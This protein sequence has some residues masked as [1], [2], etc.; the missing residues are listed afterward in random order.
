M[1]R[2]SKNDIKSKKD[3]IN[4]CLKHKKSLKYNSDNRCTVHPEKKYHIFK[5]KFNFFVE[6]I[7]TKTI[8]LNDK[9]IDY[10]FLYQCLRN[11]DKNK[12]PIMIN[13]FLSIFFYDI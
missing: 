11:N 3:L 5:N 4:L 10:S 9:F 12:N 1:K 8:K 13:N 6:G 2:I 7:G